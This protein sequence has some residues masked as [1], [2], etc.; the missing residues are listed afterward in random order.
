MIR[1]LAPLLLALGLAACTEG[2]N[3]TP[4]P[5]AP[6][7][8]ADVSLA[9]LPSPSLGPVVNSDGCQGLIA[10]GQV[11]QTTGL[12]VQPS[13]GDGAA[14]VAQYGQAV[15]T[16]GLNA[17]ARMCPFGSPA[18]D[19]VTV[20]ALTFAD[21]SQAAKLW[22]TIASLEAV[23]GVGEAALSDRSKTLLTRRGKAIVAVYL[24]VAAAP[25]ADHLSQLRSVAN[26]ALSKA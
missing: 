10:A 7:A 5:V 8:T 21:P 9:P 16:L 20:V 3:H 24:V 15:Q 26:T 19:Q 2:A 14:A 6:T 12:P 13:A 11:Q 1:R 18:G 17:R 25:D 22:T 23:G 4:L